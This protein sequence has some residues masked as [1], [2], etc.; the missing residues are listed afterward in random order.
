MALNRYSGPEEDHESR[1]RGLLR[2]GFRDYSRKTGVVSHE[3][4]EQSLWY[5]R[6]YPDSRSFRVK[7]GKRDRQKAEKP[8]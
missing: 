6:L 8:G 7:T 5:S 3:P 1:E 2:S 4:R